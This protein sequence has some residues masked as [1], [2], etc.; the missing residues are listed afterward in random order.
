[1]SRP[2]SLSIVLTA[3]HDGYGGDPVERIVKPLQFNAL[4]LA[5]AGVRCE[6]VLVEWD[7]VPGRPYLADVLSAHTGIAAGHLLRCIVVAPEYQQALAQNPRAGYLEYIAKNV[8]IR[9]AAAPWILVSNVD[10]LLGR[11]V[12]RA[13]AEGGL[14][15]GAIHRAPRFDVTLGLDQAGLAWEALED[16]ANL[17]NTPAL[18]PPIFS[19]GSGDFLLADRATFHALR[20]FNEVYRAARAGIDKNFLTKARGAGH[21]IVVLGGPVYHVNHPGSFRTSKSL[22]RGSEADSPWGNLGWHADHVAY[23]NPDEWG[24]A[25]APARPRPDGSLFLEFNWSAVPPLI[26]LRR[27]VIP[28]RR[29]EPAERADIAPV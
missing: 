27:V 25:A 13:L 16:P 29:A 12:V 19:S 5:E 14:Q 24:L 7:P 23:N 21:P 6:F 10:I 8:G 18:R 20:G 17:F 28:S 4:R 11:A 9:R 2:L 22:V 1:M 3:R 15:C 26:D